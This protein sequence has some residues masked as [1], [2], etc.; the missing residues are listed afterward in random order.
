MT[1]RRG[2]FWAAVILVVTPA[3][4]LTVLRMS[5]PRRGVLIRAQSVAPYAIVLY[6]VALVLLAGWVLRHRRQAWVLLL[7]LLGLGLHAYWLAPLYT[8]TAPSPDPEAT[9][10]TVMTINLEGGTTVIDQ[11]VDTARREHVD[12]LV[13]EDVTSESF[14]EMSLAGLSDLFPNHVHPPGFGDNGIVVLSRTGIVDPMSEDAE[15]RL[16]IATVETD[17]GPLRLLAVHPRQPTQPV[18][19]HA[20]QERWLSVVRSQH[21]DLVVGDFNATLDQAP[22]RDLEDEGYRSVTELLNQGWQRTWPANGRYRP[23]HLFPIPRLVQIDQ[24]MLG[25]DLAPIGSRTVHLYGTDHLGLVATFA[26]AETG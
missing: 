22:L 10:L 21:P 4:I 5:D 11:V 26:P 14:A 23:L 25:A 18:E 16:L 9:P 15:H 13:L 6:A 3:L 17:D 20:D 7:P 8:G 12:V 24:V 19:W 2:A 1:R